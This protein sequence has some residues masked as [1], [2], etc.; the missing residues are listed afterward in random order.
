MQ[1]WPQMDWHRH[2]VQVGMLGTCLIFAFSVARPN[3]FSFA[4]SKL[5]DEQ[6]AHCERAAFEAIGHSL[7]DFYGFLEEIAQQ[8]KTD[9]RNFHKDFGAISSWLSIADHNSHRFA[10]LLNPL[11]DFAF[12]HYAK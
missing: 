5:N 6:I 2:V 12:A 8:T 4:L 11:T 10:G 7:K 1:L 9:R 3:P